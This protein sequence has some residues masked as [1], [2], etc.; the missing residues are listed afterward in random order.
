MPQPNREQEI[1]TAIRKHLNVAK[2]GSEPITDQSLIAAV[3]HSRATFYKYVKKGSKIRSEIEDAQIEQRKNLGVL[4]S[5]TQQGDSKYVIAEL[6]AELARVK[7]GN[8]ELLANYAQLIANLKSKMVS[9]AL[10]QWA[11]TTPI[12]KPDRSVSHA[13]RSRRRKR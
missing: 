3:K 7:K 1:I 4:K 10:I 8:R 11:Q 6:R 12:K 13:G 5:E 2:T 9:D